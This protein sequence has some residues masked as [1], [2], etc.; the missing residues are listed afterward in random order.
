MID[1]LLDWTNPDIPVG[2]DPIWMATDDAR[3]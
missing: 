3:P 1:E 2:S